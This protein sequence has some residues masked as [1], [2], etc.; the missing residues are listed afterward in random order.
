MLD[1]DHFKLV[2]DTYGHAAGDTV[3]CQIA[4]LLKNS[5]RQ[6]DVV[7]RVGG[8]EFLLMLPG[9]AL[10]TALAA[11]ERLRLLIEQAQLL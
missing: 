6:G 2:N 10:T 9:V 11:A 8:E 7:A 3:L 4:S 1:I 5:A